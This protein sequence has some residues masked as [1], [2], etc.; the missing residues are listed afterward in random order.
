MN[1][2]IFIAITLLLNT[3][4]LFTQNLNTTFRSKITYP[5]QTLANIWGYTADGKEYA[6]VGASKGLIIVNITNPDNAFQITQIPGPDNLWKE[7]KTYGH[8]AYVVSEGGGGIQVVDLSGLPGS[9]L[10]SHFYT[11]DGDIAGQLGAIHALHIDTAKGYL[12]A[13]GGPLFGGRAKMFN[14]NPDPYNPKYVGVF[15]S[16]FPGNHNYVHDGYVD[17]DTMYGGHIYGGF[18]SIV[19]MSDKGNPQLL[20]TQPTPNLFTHNTW[21][22]DD[23][24]TL[25]S[26]DEKN[27]SFLTSYDISDPGNIKLLDKIQSNPGSNAM[28]HNTYILGNYAVTSWYKDGFTIIDATRPDNLVQVGNY[29]TY[30]GSGGGSD[31]C[32]GVYP[33]FPSGTIIAS[34]ITGQG[35]NNG[36]LWIITPQYTRACYLEGKVTDAVTG[37]PVSGAKIELLGSVP[38]LQE[39]SSLS[40]QFKAGRAQGGVFM[41]RVSKAG[42]QDYENP[43]LLENEKVTLLDVELYPTGS[44]TI[45]G[46]VLRTPDSIPVSGAL[47]YL[48]GPKLEYGG[49]TNFDGEFSINNV[50]PGPYDVAAGSD[51]VGVSIRHNQKLISDSTLT[52]TIYKQYRRGKESGRLS[53]GQNPFSDRTELV[54]HLPDPGKHRLVIFNAGGQIIEQYDLEGGA[55]AKMVGKDWT[56]GVYFAALQFENGPLESVKLLKTN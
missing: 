9:T 56:P 17:N 53:T 7:V 8:Y 6:L 18:F 54:Y 14:L 42:Y 2:F 52:L 24:R 45:S 4:S 10:A 22:S 31:G 16:G 13:Y 27:N 23:H 19:D 49:I 26:T 55:G 1:K 20:A 32:W 28:V 12:Y 51:D 11:G 50:Q 36:E 3:C 48:Y 46:L 35:N 40:G 38:L 21:L 47:V 29:D 25:F 41:A 30:T 43:V 37:N 15:N 39:F 5:N 44:L 33:Y 34:N